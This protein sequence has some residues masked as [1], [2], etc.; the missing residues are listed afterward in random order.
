MKNTKFIM[1][2]ISIAGCLTVGLSGIALADNVQIQ[3]TGPSS[4]NS[5]SSSTNTVMTISNTNSVVIDQSNLQYS[6]SGEVDATKNTNLT[7]QVSSGNAQNT[8]QSTT[9]VSVGNGGNGGNGSPIPGGKGSSTGGSDTTNPATP[10]TGSVLGASTDGGMG[11]GEGQTLPAVG[12]SIPMDVSALR[13]LY[14]PAALATPTVSLVNHAS[15]FSLFFL[16][17]ASLLSLLG[18]GISGFYSNRR[19]RREG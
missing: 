2:R 10:T 17:V 13:V 12:A 6:T 3:T 5:S 1:A 9:V 19:S 18:A 15:K 14:H 16:T 7:G 8:S 4:N 11:S